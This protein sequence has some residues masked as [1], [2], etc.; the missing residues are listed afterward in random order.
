DH[1]GEADLE[2]CVVEAEAEGVLDGAVHDLARNPPGPVG[3]AQ[4]IVDRP[5]VE[6]HLVRGD[7]EAVALPLRRH[8]S[9]L[10]LRISAASTTRTPDAGFSTA[11]TSAAII[12]SSVTG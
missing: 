10:A 1:P 4:E 7:R 12:C 5:A 9:I 8:G 3:A 2:V 6:L 11:R